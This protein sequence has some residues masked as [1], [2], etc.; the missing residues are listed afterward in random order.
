MIENASSLK[1]LW[2]RFPQVITPRTQLVY[3]QS[4]WLRGI[5]TSEAY[6]LNVL[7]RLAQSLVFLELE[8]MAFEPA[9]IPDGLG[10]GSPIRIIQFL[11]NTMSLKDVKFYGGMF[12]S[13]YEGWWTPQQAPSRLFLRL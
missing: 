8:N 13:E 5:V 10:Q 2:V 12:N 6:L 7:Q 11:S 1:N 9:T 3:L 4:L